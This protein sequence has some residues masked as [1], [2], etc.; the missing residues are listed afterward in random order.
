[1]RLAW[2]AYSWRFHEC[3]VAGL[4]FELNFGDGVAGKVAIS[5]EK[6]NMHDCQSNPLH[7]KSA[8]KAHNFVTRN[9]LCMPVFSR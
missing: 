5:G 8:D 1:M 4:G 6:I 2:L 7:D 9:M 3:S